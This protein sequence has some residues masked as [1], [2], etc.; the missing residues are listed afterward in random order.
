MIDAKTQFSM[1]AD[2]SDETTKINAA[3]AAALA[4]NEPLYFGPGVYGC[5]GIDPL[6]G[7]VDF[8]GAG[9]R[10]TIFKQLSATDRMFE[11]QP[12]GGAGV[13]GSAFM[14]AENFTID[15]NSKAGSAIRLNTQFNGLRNIWVKDHKSG[16]GGDYA[17]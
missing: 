5:G 8:A 13:L 16:S 12:G 4:D 3:F 6:I 10:R 2:G 11:F 14:R 17:I 7:P 9:I 15:Q 1:L